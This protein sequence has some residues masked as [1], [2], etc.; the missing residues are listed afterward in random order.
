MVSIKRE[1]VILQGT[2]HEF[3]N[4]GVMNPAVIAEGNLFHQDRCFISVCRSI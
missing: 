2:S 1:S 4:E 3:E